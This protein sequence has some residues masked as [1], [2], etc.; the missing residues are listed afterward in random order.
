MYFIFTVDVRNRSVSVREEKAS[1]NMLIT[2]L[3]ITCGGL[4]RSDV[5]PLQSDNQGVT[6]YWRSP[7]ALPSLSSLNVVRENLTQGQV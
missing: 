7:L 4:P 1:D 6:R 2:A 5:C 3:C